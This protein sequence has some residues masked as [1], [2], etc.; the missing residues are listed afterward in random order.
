[1]L[2]DLI[3]IPDQ[4]I[5]ECIDT[6][7][8]TISPSCL[9]GHPTFPISVIPK[10]ILATTYLVLSAPLQ[11]K[12]R[13]NIYYSCYLLA[14]IKGMMPFLGGE[15]SIQTPEIPAPSK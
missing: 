2:Y 5:L 14:F 3:A 12:Y 4:N 15:C 10:D 7:S 9:D 6:G 8:A 1:M 11:F 13:F